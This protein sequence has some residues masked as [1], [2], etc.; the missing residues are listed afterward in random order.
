MSKEQFG[1]SDIPEIIHPQENT[2][3]AKHF[4]EGPYPEMQAAL[5]DKEIQKAAEKLK[6][7]GHQFEL[8]ETSNEYILRVEGFKGITHVTKVGGIDIRGIIISQILNPEIN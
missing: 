8:T 7:E 4:W 6:A 1:A 2:D 3:P 5:A